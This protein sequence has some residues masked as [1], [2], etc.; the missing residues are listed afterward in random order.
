MTKAELKQRA[1]ELEKQL[2]EEDNPRKAF[3]LMAEL[4]RVRQSIAAI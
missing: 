3:E 1:F 2:W 4:K